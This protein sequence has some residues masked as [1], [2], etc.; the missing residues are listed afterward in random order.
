MNVSFLE[1]VFAAPGPYATVC[2]DVTHTTENADAELE[3]RVRALAGQLS[4]RGAPEA[5]VDAVRGR[6]LEGNEGGEAGTL[7]GRAVVVAGDGS[8]VLDEV[9]AGAPAQEF[10]SWAPHPDVLPML[11]QL[12]S[13]IPHV[14]VIADRVGA[15]IVAVGDSGQQAETTQVEGDDFHMRKVKVGGW[16]HNTYMHTAENQWEENLGRVA[17]EVDGMVRRMPVRF[18]LAAGDVRAR[19]ILSD[20]AAASWA[21]LVVSIEEGG[22]AAGADR[23]PVDRR[24]AELV[25]EHEARDI[26][27]AAEQIQAAGAHGLAVTGTADVVAALRKGQVETLLLTDPFDA[28]ATLLVGND[29]LALG[30]NQHDMD[31]L[32]VHG[33][34][35][36]AG[37][38]LVAAAVASA[39]GLIVVPQAALP[40]HSVAAV[41]RYTDDS[42]QGA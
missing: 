22:R 16:A 2:A 17:D 37:S 12:A 23:E 29:P 39:A 28:D 8:V 36:P 42:T 4:E 26:A 9:L 32:G 13:R 18:V 15:D 31:A 34:V 40:D 1:P 14:V 6:L 25:A 35:V 7:R 30:V 24:A 19:Q 10:A 11:R 20:K 21:D 38:A 27:R 41:L 5:V 33:E 3:L